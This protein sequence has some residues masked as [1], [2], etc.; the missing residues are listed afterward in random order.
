MEFERL[1]KRILPSLKGIAYKISFGHPVFSSDDLSQE[2]LSFLWQ[3]HQ[4]GAL[5]DKT[6]SYILQGCYFYLK[7]Y[8]RKMRSGKTHLSLEGLAGEDGY[9]RK[10]EAFLADDSAG[11][12]IEVLNNSLLAETIMNNGLTFKEKGLLLLYAQ[13]LTTR[14][15][16]ARAGISHVAVIKQMRKVRTKCQKYLDIN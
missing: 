14:Q 16:G 4:E 13:G 2:A 3:R 9:G 11:A 6:D 12:F 8:L 10:E 7:N 1:I 15:I 5:G